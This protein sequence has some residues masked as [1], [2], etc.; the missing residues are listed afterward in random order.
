MKSRL[1]PLRKEFTAAVLTAT[2]T[3]AIL[4]VLAV[5]NGFGHYNPGQTADFSDALP[6]KPAFAYVNIFSE[7]DKVALA[8]ELKWLPQMSVTN[9]M[10]GDYVW[11]KAALVF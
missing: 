9:T 4:P 2:L 1:H 6:G 5:E 7:F 11:L 8:I 3:V 10:E